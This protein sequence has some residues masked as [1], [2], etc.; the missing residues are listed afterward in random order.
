MI[1]L[2][3]I[4]ANIYRFFRF[5]VFGGIK[6]FKLNVVKMLILHKD[7][8]PGVNIKVWQTKELT[9][10]TRRL[11]VFIERLAGKGMKVNGVFLIEAFPYD[12]LTRGV[13]YDTFGYI[14]LISN[15]GGD[16]LELVLAHEI[17]HSKYAQKHIEGT[18]MD[19][20]LEEAT[21]AYYKRGLCTCIHDISIICRESYNKSWNLRKYLVR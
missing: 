11:G 8:R 5:I 16:E 17:I 15:M 10:K 14:V 3:L 1:L 20:Y 4:W 19:T 13:S 21:K 12:V 18:I 2:T 6:D 9:D 7:H